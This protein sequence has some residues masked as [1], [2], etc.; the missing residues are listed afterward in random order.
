MRNTAKRESW[1]AICLAIMLI[2]LSVLVVTSAGGSGVAYA[3]NEAGG[4]KSNV[5]QG[6]EN[7]LEDEYLTTTTWEKSPNAQLNVLG[8]DPIVNYIPKSAFTNDGEHLYVGRD[9][10]YFVYTFVNKWDTDQLTFVN[11]QSVVLVFLIDYDDRDYYLTTKDTFHYT[12]QP[13][14]QR[15]YLTLMPN[16]S[17][18]YIGLADAA[19][20]SSYVTQSS[21]WNEFL[22]W[23]Y[24]KRSPYFIA[25]G[26]ENI[27]GIVVPLP[28]L[29]VDDFYYADIEMFYL[30]DISIGATLSNEQ[31]VNYGETGYD[32]AKDEGMFFINTGID[33]SAY[34]YSEEQDDLYI[35]AVIYTAEFVAN[36]AVNALFGASGIPFAG[37]ALSL[38]QYIVNVAG[39]LDETALEYI[40]AGSFYGVKDFPSTKHGQLEASGGYT[41][42]ST[43]IS[44]DEQSG[45]N[46]WLGL[47]H[48]FT[49]FFEMS[50][51]SG[52]DPGWRTNIYTVIDVGV[53]CTFSDMPTVMGSTGFFVNTINDSRSK[54][55]M[56]DREAEAYVKAHETNIDGKDSFAFTAPR[57]GLYEVSLTNG[58]GVDYIITD[59]ADTIVYEPISGGMYYFEEG[60]DYII[61][62][63]NTTSSLKRPT[64]KVGM[65]TLEADFGDNYTF[66]LP[67]GEEMYVKLNLVNPFTRLSVQGTGMK[68]TGTSDR[69]DFMLDEMSETAYDIS[70]A[71]VTFIRIENTSTAA[72]EGSITFSDIAQITPGG[73]NAVT[74][75]GNSKYFKFVPE[76]ASYIFR[77]ENATGAA[78]NFT[79]YSPGTAAAISDIQG[80]YVLV[81]GLTAGSVYWIGLYNAYGSDADI[82]LINEAQNGSIQWAIND[83]VVTGSSYN[84]YNGQ[85]YD[86]ALMIN[87]EKYYAHIEVGTI[88]G[89]EYLTY[90]NEV[91]MVANYSSAEVLPTSIRFEVE[92]F[93]FAGVGS[94]IIDGLLDVYLKNPV[95]YIKANG[96]LKIQDTLS[97]ETEVDV[98]MYVGDPLIEGVD[99]KVTYT[100][101]LLQECEIVGS[102]QVVELT[103][104]SLSTFSF[105]CN[106]L[107]T[108]DPLIR[109]TGIVYDGYEYSYSSSDTESSFNIL[110]GKG[111]GTSSDPYIINCNQH[112][113]TFMLGATSDASNQTVT[114]WKLTED[115]D[116]SSFSGGIPSE[117]YGV[118]DGGG[119]TLSGLTI[120][121]PAESFTS[122]KSYG[123][124]EENYGTIKNVT[125]SDV[126][127]SAP[128]W[129]QGAWVFVGTVAGI[130]RPG[131]V[132]DNV[133][134]VGADINI[135]RN[136]AR[137]GGIAGVNFSVIKNCTVGDFDSAV[138]MFGNGDMGAIC[139]ESSGTIE[140]C[141][142]VAQMDH[143]PSV[144]NRSVGGIVGYAPSGSIIDCSM[145][146]AQINVTG[147][148]A[149]ICPNIGA[150]AGHI[151]SSTVISGGVPLILITLDALSEAQKVN[152]CTDGSRLYGY[153]G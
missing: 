63:T 151:T 70:A 12:I 22:E 93:I 105:D 138:N 148:D 137:I 81:T 21:P 111:S 37:T 113:A 53:S 6:L 33:I 125:F 139:G 50:N 61:E 147:S 7:Y 79:V 13:L 88:A 86:V 131:G 92:N 75:D 83:E 106:A 97:H 42:K 15:E 150:V 119:H 120:E 132:I 145:L 59:S 126:T 117:F 94:E 80:D 27:D 107:L 108:Y 95:N 87:G 10:G 47:G 4:G 25:E 24:H 64:V 67:A 56:E 39:Y 71:K 2:L 112:Y 23:T 135:N 18:G 17:N 136:M 78:V 40:E 31:D 14:F 29:S 122:D 114:Y 143:Y 152:C 30:S 74:I 89:G 65:A 82:T 54:P 84:M 32:V 3:A 76:A 26:V 100:N 128:V 121:I 118:F 149:N 45:I 38:A 55:L 85:T 141:V 8:E 109:I 20:F 44:M 104:D 115:L 16:D 116:I 57:N 68:L 28:Q 140:N 66:T 41:Y 52:V 129:H 69:L 96:A 73:E 134:L 36:Q 127:I 19:E 124:F 99:Y 60:Q 144:A 77:Y 51:D 46:A 11:K 110:Y 91:L 62:L 58:S 123:W 72:Q 5:R 101:G 153:M 146:L 48:H 43:V 35:D 98:T 133:D 1:Y 90:Q 34:E 130:N 9:Y 102:A 142:S 103:D 49:G